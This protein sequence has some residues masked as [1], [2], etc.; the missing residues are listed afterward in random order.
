M[1]SLFPVKERRVNIKLN[2]LKPMKSAGQKNVSRSFLMKTKFKI[3]IFKYQPL[4]KCFFSLVCFF[5]WQ[6][7]QPF[8]SSPFLCFSGCCM[9]IVFLVYE[10]L[11]FCF[12]K[13]HNQYSFFIFHVQCLLLSASHCMH[14]HQTETHSL[15]VENNQKKFFLN[16]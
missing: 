5:I 3:L 8:Y 10:K 4:K 12:P 6:P 11:L 16:L 1:I 14:S 2:L 15:V 13:L 7:P 9:K